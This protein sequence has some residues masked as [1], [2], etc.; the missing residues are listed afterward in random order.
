MAVYRQKLP[1][2]A[3]NNRSAPSLL[4]VAL[5]KKFGIF[6]NTGVY[7]LHLRRSSGPDYSHTHRHVVNLTTAKTDSGKSFDFAKLRTAC[8]GEKNLEILTS[9]SDYLLSERIPQ[10]RRRTEKNFCHRVPQMSVHMDQAFCKYRCK[11]TSTKNKFIVA[12][13]PPW[14][15]KK[16]CWPDPPI[17]VLLYVVP[18]NNL[19]SDR[20]MTLLP[21]ARTSPLGVDRVVYFGTVEAAYYD[22]FGTRAFW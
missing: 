21:V 14:E 2:G 5:F 8:R 12:N 4:V 22:H 11:W 18:S 17:C 1:L 16:K 3:L 15:E 13:W 10:V 6:L 7:R 20:K 9:K 19:R